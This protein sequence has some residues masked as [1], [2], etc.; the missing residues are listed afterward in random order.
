MLEVL[1]VDRVIAVDLQRPGHQ[2]EGTFFNVPVETCITEGLGINYF[3][4]V[5]RHGGWRGGREGREGGK[6]GGRGECTSS[7]GTCSLTRLA[8]S[9]SYPPSLPPSLL[10]P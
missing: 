10:S 3:A 1:G 5:G 7:E 9:S 8:I 4:E 2:S 6:E